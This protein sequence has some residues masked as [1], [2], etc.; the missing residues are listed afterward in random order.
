MLR[1]RSV[2][3]GL[4]AALSAGAALAA[5]AS[6]AAASSMTISGPGAIVESSTAQ[7]D[8]K[9]T[10]DVAA[11]VE[12][13]VRRAG[14]AC[15]PSAAA[16]PGTPLLDRSAIES[17]FAATAVQAF[18]DA[19][20]YVICGWARDTSSAAQPV[21]A[22]ASTTLSVRAP[23][24]TL[25]LAV[26]PSVPLDELFTV[27]TVATAEIERLAYVGIVPDTP[28]GCPATYGALQKTPNSTPVLAQSGTKVVGGPTTFRE[29]I[30]M[31]RAGR[32]LACGYFHN[33]SVDAAPQATAKAAFIVAKSCE[34][35][36]VAGTT[37]AR[38]K[39]LLKKANCVVGKTKKARSAKVKKGRVVKASKKA[40]TILAP[41]ATV[42]LTVSKGR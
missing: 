17:A 36:D 16:D 4:L 3:R 32:F 33:T 15:A 27:A 10:L 31:P 41:G 28:Q 11:Y 22:S 40:G 23:K 6:A 5:P 42:G 39:K 37:L 14:A 35:P 8:V 38:A 2:R 19:G 1:P 7:I 26:R 29:Q 20:E 13:K 18:G 12:V 30:S 25:A 9:A 34:V 24:L 21:V